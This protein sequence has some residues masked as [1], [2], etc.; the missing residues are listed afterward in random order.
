MPSGNLAD[1]GDTTITTPTD[2]QVLT[3]DSTSSKWVNGAGGGGTTVV[4]NPS[5]EA[6]DELEKLQVGNTIYSIPPG[7]SGGSGEGWV[8]IKG[9]LTAGQTSITLTSSKIKTTSVID[10]YTS[11]FGVNPTA[12][13]VS[14]GSATLTF[15]AQAT[16]MDVMISVRK[17]SEEKL[18]DLPLSALESNKIWFAYDGVRGFTHVLDTLGDGLRIYGGESVN[19]WTTSGSVCIDLTEFSSVIPSS[20]TAMKFHFSVFTLTSYAA[21]RFFISNTKY[22]GDQLGSDAMLRSNG[23][24]QIE[25]SD[26]LDSSGFYTAQIDSQTLSSGR[27]L[28]I[29]VMTGSVGGTQG[30]GNGYN[31]TFDI[32]VDGIDFV[33]GGNS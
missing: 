26:S 11:I 18:F 14:D 31:G 10:Y 4:A 2:G 25:S 22:E 13:T 20:L 8:D 7:G 29:M 9:T 24:A 16:D 33:T 1:L 21:V 5:G 15:E 30:Y 23:F 27:Y 28:Y 19:D 32:Q 6:T 12:V 17:L 3:Y